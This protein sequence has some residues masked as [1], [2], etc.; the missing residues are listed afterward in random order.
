MYPSSTQ[1]SQSV[2]LRVRSAHASSD[3]EILAL[4]I[5][6]PAALPRSRRASAAQQLEP[7][8]TRYDKELVGALVKPHER[9]GRMS[10]VHEPR[11]C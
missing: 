9:Q 2:R 10:F 1:S 3:A 8:W 5:S 4:G 6:I 7:S 11:S